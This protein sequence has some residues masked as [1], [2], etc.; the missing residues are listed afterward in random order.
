MSLKSLARDHRKTLRV[1]LLLLLVALCVLNYI[2]FPKIAGSTYLSFYTKA[3]V[4][5]ALGTL[6]LELAWKD[7]E[8]NSSITSRDPLLYLSGSLLLI[9]LPIIV[10]GVHLD[11]KYNDRQ[12]S[13]LD[14]LFSVPFIL[15]FLLGLTVWLLTIAPAQY[16]LNYVCR[17]PSMLINRSSARIYA[18]F[19]SEGKLETV[20][21]KKG[22]PPDLES[23]DTWWDASMRGKTQKLTNAYS[24]AL[25]VALA[26]VLA[27]AGGA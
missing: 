1:A 15:I 25:L 19:S 10:L 12:I 23:P 9:G 16:F 24:A 2:L 17:A 11:R 21:P 26:W 27:A 14:F 6:I 18:R 4:V 3:G 20:I 8:T 22:Q 13:L 5:V 7:I